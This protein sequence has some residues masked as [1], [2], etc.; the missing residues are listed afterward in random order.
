MPAPSPRPEYK[1]RCLP[2]VFT[3]PVTNSY[4]TQV[5]GAY[6][7]RILLRL[8]NILKFKELALTYLMKML[9][10][11]NETFSV[12]SVENMA[13]LSHCKSQSF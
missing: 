12:P 3:Q 6:R 4:T 10:E 1:D 8:A 2:V 9:S 5:H 11:G 13:L 7:F